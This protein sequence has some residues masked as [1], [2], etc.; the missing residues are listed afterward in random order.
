MTGETATILSKN[1]DGT[2]R[3]SWSCRL[4]GQN[5]HE[6]VFYGEFE[7]EVSHPELGL[8][9]RGT[10]SYEY[11]WLDRWFNVFRFHEP[12]GQLRNYYCNV[13]TP[14]TFADGI[15]E[16]IDLDL[17]LLVWPNL[18]YSI[19][20]RDE[21]CSNA[22]RFGYPSDVRRNAEDALA[23]LIEMAKSGTLLSGR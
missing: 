23:A 5:G 18:K 7:K 12:D 15:L 20:D 2:L 6:L 9:K 21:F 16:Y 22:D 11:Y 8:I 14:P 19:L 1:Y 17:D 4:F 10:I 13:S 3:K